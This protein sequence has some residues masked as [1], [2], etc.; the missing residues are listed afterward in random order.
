MLKRAQRIRHGLLI[1][2]WMLASI[3]VPA[4]IGPA[5]AQPTVQ[6]AR[7]GESPERTRFVME[8]SQD[9][10]YRVFTLPDPFRVV[11][12]LPELGWAVPDDRQPKARGLVTGLRFGLFAPGTSRVVLDVGKPAHLQKVFVIPPREGK[13]HRLVIDIEEV[14]REQYF[15]AAGQAR[16][17]AATGEGAA[18]AQSGPTL[19]TS[20]AP[21]RSALAGPLP[22]PKP[23]PPTAK[24]ADTRP[25]V[26]IDPGHGGVDPGAIGV[27]GAYEKNIALDYG[28][29]LYAALKASGRYRPVM[30]RNRDVFLKLRQRIALA[31]KAK[32]DLF[33]SL[34]ANIH[35]SSK[36]RGA[37]VYTL[38]ETASDK[39]AAAIAAAENAAD[40]LAGVDL[41]DQTGDVR[42][43]LID[44]AQ[45]ETM[46][47]SKNFANDLVVE[48]GK[49]VKLLRNTHRFAGFAVLKSPTIPSVLFEIGY[50]SNRQEERLLRSRAH[51]DKVVGS[52]IR[53]VDVFFRKQSA[54][55]KS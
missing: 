44:L 39:E 54:T 5:M 27:S 1:L 30:T 4:G 22:I 53:A 18:Q 47:L 46:N 7:I 10:P 15:A 49:D 33:I 29:A 28:R 41:T 24:P 14:S 50:M 19:A 37:S 42:D 52:I 21:L 35:R 40:V 12:D 51:R 2:V 11:V 31:H 17:A 38:S 13:P 32:G 55:R 45:R 9:V 6:A 16:R 23:T 48:V 36:I 8:L 20:E 3:G 34:H 43:I 25:I 26:V